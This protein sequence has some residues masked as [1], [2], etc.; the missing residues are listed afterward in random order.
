MTSSISKTKKKSAAKNTK[1][2]A[3]DAATSANS[4]KKARTP[5]V[6]KTKAKPKTAAAAKVRRP[7]PPLVRT[8]AMRDLSGVAR[9]AVLRYK[10]RQAEEATKPVLSPVKPVVSPIKPI[11]AQRIKNQPV[12]APT[13]L[14]LTG[15]T[16]PKPGLLA[17][18]TAKSI[19]PDTTESKTKRAGLVSNATTFR[20]MNAKFDSAELTRIYNRFYQAGQRSGPKADVYS[21]LGYGGVGYVR[22]PVTEDQFAAFKAANPVIEAQTMWQMYVADYEEELE[23]YEQGMADYQDEVAQYKADMRQYNEDLAAW[24]ES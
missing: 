7:R 17:E 24:E 9:E 2:T 1:D 20:E 16:P 12:Q 5:V 23:A 13:K 14:V 8:Q 3:N 18:T 19:S 4:R 10:A 11:K 6:T 15:K 21:M 22:T